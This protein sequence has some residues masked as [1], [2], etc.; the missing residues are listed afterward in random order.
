[1]TERIQLNDADDLFDICKDNVF[2]AVFTSD[3]PSSQ[4]ALSRLVSALIGLE[5]SITEIRANEPPVD[6]LQERQIRYDIN[7]VAENGELLNVEM[8][9][10]PSDFELVRLE[11]HVGKLFTSQELKGVNKNYDNLQ[12]A[13]QITILGKGR[14]FPDD[15]FFH[16]FEYYDPERNVSLGGRSRIITVELSKLEKVVEKSAEEMSGKELW[17]VFFKYLNDKKKRRKI[18]EIIGR[19]EGIAMASELLM[20]ISKDHAERLLDLSEEKFQLDIQSKIVT[21]ERKGRQEGREE[22]KQEINDLLKSGK[23]PE[24]I[25]KGFST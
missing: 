3:T 9:L 17:A 2:K 23:S 4:K 21:A 24:E 6:S 19:E 16:T 12:R 15:Y 20:R 1:M 25:I 13:Y 5:V 7:C 8:S 22:V 10:N 11:Y 14:F 18:N